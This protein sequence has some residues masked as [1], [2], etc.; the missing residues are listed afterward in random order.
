MD[1]LFFLARREAA[2]GVASSHDLPSEPAA[3]AL[4]LEN[5]SALAG[6]AGVLGVEKRIRPLRD[7]TCRSFPVW[8]L[9]AE[10]TAR[11]GALDDAQLDAA[12]ERW[13]KNDATCLDADW[14]ELADCLGDL[15]A[16]IRA[17]EWGTTLFALLEERAW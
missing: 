1:A 16:A 17:R 11:I 13:H 10:L 8:D 3:D 4:R 5:P 12:A 7:A 6:L 15:R 9:G 2:V 14:S